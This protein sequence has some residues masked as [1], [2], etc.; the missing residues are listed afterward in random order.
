MSGLITQDI[1]AATMTAIADYLACNVHTATVGSV[2]AVNS[3]GTIDVQPILN[4]PNT[5]GTQ[6]QH[7]ILPDVPMMFNQNTVL[8]ITVSAG[9]LV[10]LI[11]TKESLENFSNSGKIANTLLNQQFGQGNAFAIPLIFSAG[12]NSV[13]RLIDE[14]FATFFNAHIHASPGS[15]PSIL[16]GDSPPAVSI[17]TMAT[18]AVKAA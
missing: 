14:R 9:D 17:S 15:P 2:A 5:D 4:K 18:T 7:A 6:T 8:S 3:D 11:F 12:L 10:L 16:I 1:G 13:N